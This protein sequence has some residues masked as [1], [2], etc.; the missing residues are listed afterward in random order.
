METRNQ[1]FQFLVLKYFYTAVEIQ[2]QFKSFFPIQFCSPNA[3]AILGNEMVILHGR[4]YSKWSLHFTSE[5][6]PTLGVTN[7]ELIN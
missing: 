4:F 7:T 2:Q 1:Q 3:T 6:G 5:N